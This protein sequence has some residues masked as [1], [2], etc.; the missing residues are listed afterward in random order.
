MNIKSAPALVALCVCAALFAAGCAATSSPPV[1]GG[2]GERARL[3]SQAN[4]GGAVNGNAR[5]DDEKARSPLPPPT[6]LV[7][8]YAGALAAE[9]KH[10]LEARLTRLKERA[11]VEFAVAIVE[12]TGGADIDDYSLSVARGWG[13]GPPKE[14]GGGGLLLLF[15]LKDRRWRLQVSRSLEADLPNGV[16]AE[17][18]EGMKPHLQR[19]DFD[20]ALGAFV[21]GVVRR[22]A[23]RRG[24]DA[25]D[26]LAPKAGVLEVNPKD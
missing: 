12:T 3:L 13:V 5:G 15:A 9:Q 24:F 7:N 25:E 18:G 16:S 17:V 26:V 22:L 23:A 4:M 10:A 1:E 21:E 2:V 14:Q 19:G 8:D 20:A 11:R 6:G